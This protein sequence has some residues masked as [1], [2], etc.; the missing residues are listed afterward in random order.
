[1]VKTNSDTTEVKVQASLLSADF[2]FL[3]K[4]REE[5]TNKCSAIPSKALRN[6]ISTNFIYTN[7]VNSMKITIDRYCDN[8]IMVDRMQT[9]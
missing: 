5:D 6:L 4:I 2:D 8:K 1:M 7:I 3:I 9:Q